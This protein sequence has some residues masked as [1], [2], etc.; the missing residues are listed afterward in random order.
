MARIIKS[1]ETSEGKEREKL[2]RSRIIDKDTFNAQLVARE[3][4]SESEKEKH[5]KLESAY[6]SAEGI[7][8]QTYQTAMDSAHRA[9][10]AELIRTFRDL[11]TLLKAGQREANELSR[12]IIHKIAGDGVEIPEGSCGLAMRRL[13]IEA[14]SN[15]FHKLKVLQLPLWVE[16]SESTRADIGKLIIETETFMIKCSFEEVMTALN[17]SVQDG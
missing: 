1:G 16:P 8:T 6:E 7:E 17:L 15:D 13:R 2:N 11:E 9:C 10:L 5:A 4:L 14:S 3:I 12:E